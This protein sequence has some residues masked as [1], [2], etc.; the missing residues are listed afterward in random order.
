M[1]PRAYDRLALLR[2]S[3]VEPPAR[4]GESPKLARPFS[5]SRDDREALDLSTLEGAHE[6]A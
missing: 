1:S 3:P 5:P 2:G 4:A 6:S